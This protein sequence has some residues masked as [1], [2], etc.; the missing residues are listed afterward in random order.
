MNSALKVAVYEVGDVD[1]VEAILADWPHEDVS[2]LISYALMA[3]QYDVANSLYKFQHSHLEKPESITPLQGPSQKNRAHRDIEYILHCVLGIAFTTVPSDH[4]CYDAM[5]DGDNQVIFNVSQARHLMATCSNGM[6]YNVSLALKYANLYHFILDPIEQHDL[7]LALQRKLR[8]SLEEVSEAK[9]DELR[10]SDIDSTVGNSSVPLRVTQVEKD[11]VREYTQDHFQLMNDLLR[12]NELGEP[13]SIRLEESLCKALLVV[14]ATNKMVNSTRGENTL[15]RYEGEV[16]GSIDLAMSNGVPVE[17][18]G[19]NSYSSNPDGAQGF[20]KLQSKTVLHGSLFG[21]IS[22]ISIQSAEA[23]HLL[24]PFCLQTH[25]RREVRGVLVYDAHVVHGMMADS[26]DEYIVD[27]A[28]CHA[29]VILNKAY[30]DN[31]DPLFDVCR[32]NHA[33]AHHVRVVS[34]VDSVVRY[35]S[36]HATDPSFKQYCDTLVTDDINIIKVLLALS[37]IGRESEIAFFD[38]PDLYQRYQ[39][40][41]VTHLKIFLT[42]VCNFDDD[43]CEFYAEILRYMGDPN[44]PH[45]ATGTEQQKQ[46]KIMINHIITF[47]H[48]LDLARCYD[49]YDYQRSLHVYGDVCDSLSDQPVVELNDRQSE[50]L[51]QLKLQ[52]RLALEYTGDRVMF[53]GL[54]LPAVGHLEDEFRLCNRNVTHCKERCKQVELMVTRCEGG[55]MIGDAV[56]LLMNE[57]DARGALQ[58]LVL[59]PRKALIKFVAERKF[60]EALVW[61]DDPAEF[62]KAVSYL[63]CKQP[64]YP[65]AFDQLIVYKCIEWQECNIICY[66]VSQVGIENLLV[67]QEWEIDVF[68]GLFFLAVRHDQLEL[69]EEMLQYPIEMCGIDGDG[70]SVL[71]IVINNSQH[72]MLRLLLQND[73]VDVNQVNAQGKSPLML[74][75]LNEQW[76]MAVSILA[77]PEL[78]VDLQDE[79]DRTAFMYIVEHDTR[80]YLHDAIFSHPTFKPNTQDAHGITLLHDAVYSENHVLTNKLLALPDIDVSLEQEDGFTVL[81]YAVIRGLDKVVERVL[82]INDR[83]INAQTKF[84]MTALLYALLCDNDES[85][86]IIMRYP[87]VDLN[88]ADHNGHTAMYYA[89]QEKKIAVVEYLSNKV[90]NINAQFGLASYAHTPLTLALSEGNYVIVA[91]LLRNPDVDVNIYIGG[92]TPLMLAADRGDLFAVEVLLTRQDIKVG[93]LGA[94]GQSAL[95]LAVINNKVDIVRL[96]LPYSTAVVNNKMKY[97]DTPLL[98]AVSMGRVDIVKVLLNDDAVDIYVKNADGKT[99]FDLASESGFSEI[100]DRLVEKLLLTEDGDGCSFCP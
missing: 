57:G 97:G 90:A 94:L 18:R 13:D 46:E 12:G 58:Q 52:A 88:L 10:L 93:M 87:T 62:F 49:Q 61:L 54:G 17:R 2:A 24:P 60:W 20:R 72:R 23:E 22:S 56:C 59:L 4:G 100:R 16:L 14:S 9:S 92:L 68:Q 36:R 8:E 98:T 50:D 32:H 21:S 47:A 96:L 78:D 31:E 65:Y 71:H 73:R 44:F 41:S 66:V 43:Q 19:M 33:L 69:Y 38:N 81:M 55:G 25:D 48:K 26:T 82:T 34:Y 99:A 39:E 30:Q 7:L 40:A 64:D 86:E 83:N 67:E 95:H 35:F 70:N 15:V 53:A 74:A 84:G 3:G 77:H 28:L 91:L 6:T 63:V 29:S 37:K 85:T 1:V 51:K 75:F 42:E 80:S 27:L 76:V 89:I 79:D 11:A 5:R 45:K